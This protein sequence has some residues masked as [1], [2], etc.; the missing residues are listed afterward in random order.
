LSKD[1][2]LFGG[3]A[4][5][6]CREIIVQDIL[7]DTMVEEIVLET[8]IIDPAGVVVVVVVVVIDDMMIEREEMEVYNLKEVHQ[9]NRNFKRLV[10]FLEHS[11]HFISIFDPPQEIKWSDLIKLSFLKLYGFFNLLL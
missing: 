11:L 5:V 1:I 7:V 8:I 2:F 10:I 3:Q 9:I 4:L 6:Q